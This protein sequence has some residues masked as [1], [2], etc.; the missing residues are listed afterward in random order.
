M[1]SLL[2]LHIWTHTVKSIHVL[3]PDD[4]VNFNNRSPLSSTRFP[5]YSRPGISLISDI[6]HTIS[7]SFNHIKNV[8][9]SWAKIERNIASFLLPVFMCYPTTACHCRSRLLTYPWA[10]ISNFVQ[11]APRCHL[12]V[13]VLE[14]SAV[15]EAV[16]EGDVPESGGAWNS[17]TVYWTTIYN[18]WKLSWSVTGSTST[19]SSL[20]FVRNNIS[21]LVQYT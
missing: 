7:Y 12:V 8:I 11:L 19:R 21:T 14:G 9:L 6:L 18:V 17:T 20:R 5:K 15:L 3:I 2:A 13:V 4:I 10:S 1:H 16:G